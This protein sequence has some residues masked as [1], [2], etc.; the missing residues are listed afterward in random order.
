MPR[1]FF[2]QPE[3][4]VLDGIFILQI[5]LTMKNLK[6]VGFHGAK[7]TGWLQ[8]A[9]LVAAAHILSS[10]SYAQQLL[11][12]EL[13]D[14]AGD[15]TF[16]YF[17][18]PLKSTTEFHI[19]TSHHFLAF[20]Y[21]TLEMKDLRVITDPLP[22]VEA[23]RSGLDFLPLTDPPN[24]LDIR[25]TR[26]G[27]SYRLDRGSQIPRDCKLIESGKFFQRRLL[28]NL[29]FETGGPD[30]E[31]TLEITSWPDR[32]S[33]LLEV[34]P[35][36]PQET[37]VLELNLTIPEAIRHSVTGEGNKLLAVDESG[38][39]FLF[40]AIGQGNEVAADGNAFGVSH[41][42]REDGTFTI[43]LV[44]LPVKGYGGQPLEA[45][46]VN[47]KG[48]LVISAEQ[49]S[50]SGAVLATGHD[51]L[52]GWYEI[53]LRN[54]GR[55]NDRMERVKMELT[56]PD[57]RERTVRL[58]F[59]KTTGTGVFGITGI[60]AMIRDN[61]LNP[62]GLPV[63]VSKNWHRHEE[64]HFMGPWFRGFTMMRIPAGATVEFEFTL[65]NAMWGK[66]PAA[67]HNQLSLTGWKGGWGDNQL[68]E[69]TAI[70]A[71]G[72]TV[73][74]EPDGGLAQ[75]MVCDVRPLMIESPD[76]ALRPN[77]WDWT[78]NVGGADFFRFYDQSGEKQFIT[79][80]KSHYK[81]VCPN[82]TE[83][84]Y[85]GVTQGE[86]ADYELTSSIYRT[87]DYVR[88]VYR[89]RLEVNE[90]I[91]FS[92]L[93]ILQAGT[94]TYS[95][96]GERK[97][98]FGDENGLIEE[99]DTGWGGSVY[100][101]TGLS[102]EGSIPW[103]SMHEGVIRDP[104]DWGTWANRGIIVRQWD[105]RIG[106][107]ASGPWFSE[108]G[109]V[110]RG[111]ATSL[112][113]INPPPGT[114]SLL[115]GDYIEAEI[116][117][118]VLPQEV[119]SY[120][121]SNH[122]FILELLHHGDTW[123]PV[124]REAIGNN[125]H[126]TAARGT[127]LRT[128]PVVVQ[129]D[130]GNEAEIEI[131]GGLGYVP[132]T[133]TGLTSHT[134][135]SPKITGN[136]RQIDV[137]DQQVHGNDY[138]QTDYDPVTKTWEITYSV[139]LDSVWGFPA[140]DASLIIYNDFDQVRTIPVASASNVT[141]EEGVA[142]PAPSESNPNEKVGKVV[143]R[144]A[145]HGSIMFQRL[146]DYLDL[147]VNTIFRVMSFYADDIVP[148][149]SNIRLALR[150][151]GDGP[152]Q[153]MLTQNI[154]VSGAWREHV[155]DVSAAHSRPMNQFN[156]VW[157]FFN[158]PDD[159]GSTVG[160]TTYIDMLRGPPLSINHQLL[161]LYTTPGGDTVVVDFSR[162]HHLLREVHYPIFTLYA[163]GDRLIPIDRT[164]HD[165]LHI[166]LHVREG[167]TPDPGES[168]TLSY[169]YGR[170]NNTAGAELPR[171]KEKAVVNNI[172]LSAYHA[173]IT[174]LDANSLD[175][176]FEALVESD[177]IGGLTNASGETMLPLPHG[178][179]PLSISRPGYFPID[180]T[181]YLLSDTTLTFHLIP[182]MASVQF[183]VSD[184]QNP[185]AGASV[186]FGGETL[187]T[188]ASGAAVFSD[189]NV[190]S[191]YIYLVSLTGYES[192]SGPVTLTGDTTVHVVLELSS[193]I[194]K[195][196]AGERIYP[197]P[198]SGIL[199]VEVNGTTENISVMSV[200]GKVIREFAV[201]GIGLYELPLQDIPDGV[202][203]LMIQNDQERIVVKILKQP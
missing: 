12:S 115:P 173:T 79:R 16:M 121:G 105:A 74:Y 63:Q 171:F 112:V 32:L 58:N 40:H 18:K 31:V 76:P 182:S 183:M 102:T 154:T 128:F 158:S 114:A 174:V 77:R 23:V 192:Q 131:E 82:L 86:E 156:E 120:Y 90:K 80:L 159:A 170:I 41:G 10:P 43:E 52:R 64:D 55:G 57:D 157:L 88:I 160:H 104:S 75:S 135:F 198:F 8:A 116:V 70:G 178:T 166:Y 175:P 83:V 195:M 201:S 24:L 28:A 187:Q 103:I 25:Y 26:N 72:E 113:E 17:P 190:D 137:S 100:R 95:Y 153:Y 73:C 109:A 145:R 119:E 85:A 162:S 47:E 168:L 84:T 146:P 19:Q 62:A 15:Y 51:P 124:Y 117:Q 165:T 81:R 177:T 71:W 98:A 60:S 141:F 148:D 200:F 3:K 42:Y 134:G 138:W 108:Y 194:G 149:A 53:F 125:L 147:S 139:P 180:T 110:A 5:N 123:R 67:S 38:N 91:D 151:N 11:P 46:L 96:T 176:L 184:G 185:L 150:N 78:P 106:G 202:Y 152:S 97:F 45:L 133:F 44:L 130:A 50:P 161:D 172:P 118:V 186:E 34:R 132:V 193:G 189:L 4:R 6:S 9:G 35:G 144:A 2:R 169:I 59:H 140:D 68:W 54:D 13:W 89:I 126:V 167:L 196:P 29:G 37:D 181:L 107:E 27:T 127:V 56:N 30:S 33:F 136:G 179:N 101:K 48:D 155:F 94:D 69:Q 99:W 122:D 39:G 163:S 191:T 65:V 129:V 197:N 93:A 87:D 61:N 21:K 203:L 188:G 36:S 66:L 49:V 92:R 164:T 143:R 1:L 14:H 111:T 7:K 199:Y 142:N 20:D 22:E